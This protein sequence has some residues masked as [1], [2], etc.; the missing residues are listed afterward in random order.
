MYNVKLYNNIKSSAL[1][2]LDGS[3]YKVS[4]AEENP[5]AILVRSAKLHD[6]EFNPELLCIGRAGAGVNNIPLERCAEAGI[7]VFNTPGANAGA[8]K[9]L[10]ICSLFL[11]SR[12]IIGGVNWVK[13]I[14]G[15]GDEVPAL[16][17]KNKSKYVGPEILGKTLGVVGLG[18]IGAK[19]ANAA[20][21]LG[22]NVIGYDPYLSVD[23]AWA[24]SPMIKRVN[25]LDS[26]Y[27]AS[28]YISLH[29]P[30]LDSTRHLVNKD[31]IKKMKAGVRILNLSRAELVCDEDIISALESEYVASYVTDFPNA[32]TAGAKGVIPIPHLGA[33][34]PESEENCVTMACEEIREY[35]ENGNIINSVNIAN[36]ST[37]RNGKPRVCIIHK[38]GDDAIAKLIA[39]VSSLG[40]NV[41]NIANAV[42][43]GTNPS[44]VIMDINVLKDGLS[45]ALEEV[46]GVIKV[47]VLS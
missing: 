12:D 3:M 15:E 41:D 31:S 37:P 16:V 29:L 42:G 17:E 27:A 25:D 13:T 30:L 19:I 23:G 46:E 44:Y 28:D 24:L 26:L 40:I 35:I 11:S 8:V 10:A 36:L 1:E 4:D 9:E 38:N 7:V 45:S 47:R 20:L 14:A 39:K 33:S 32:K 21:A 2:I 18:A 34:T 22:M 6:L 5:T 43:K